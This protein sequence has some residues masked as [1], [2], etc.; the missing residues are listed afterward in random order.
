MLA[1]EPDC[2][3]VIYHQSLIRTTINSDVLYS[4]FPDLQPGTSRFTAHVNPY[5]EN[6]FLVIK[7]I[8]HYGRE[9]NYN[10]YE[11]TMK[12]CDL[13]TIE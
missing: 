5:T 11:E 2:S 9:I 10:S 6:V 4:L 1:K 8:S 7:C 12:L 13:V 3:A